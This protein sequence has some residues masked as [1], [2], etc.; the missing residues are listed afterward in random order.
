KNGNWYKLEWGGNGAT[1]GRS[2]VEM[3]AGMFENF[4]KGVFYFSSALSLRDMV[5]SGFQRDVS[6]FVRASTGGAVNVAAT[7]G[8]WPGL[9]GGLVYSTVDVFFGWGWAEEPLTDWM[10]AAHSEC[11][12]YEWE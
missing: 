1:G 11:S 4:G 8:G 5:V 9:V 10:C 7:F 3:T 2:A 12:K 6:G